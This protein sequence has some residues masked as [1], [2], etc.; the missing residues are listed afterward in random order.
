MIPI[1]AKFRREILR[2][3]AIFTGED[4]AY[5]LV[6]PGT[7]AHLSFY[8]RWASCF[9]EINPHLKYSLEVF[10]RLIQ[11]FEVETL[12]PHHVTPTDNDLF[13]VCLSARLLY[14]AL[15]PQDRQSKRAVPL[16]ANH[17]AIP[18][19]LARPKLPIMRH[20]VE[21]FQQMLAPNISYLSDTA[22]DLLLW[23]LSLGGLGSMGY[24]PH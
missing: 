24:S 21:T 19:C 16:F 17:I 7:L 15:Y 1:S 10:T 4:S 2:E 14:Q 23:M 12:Q 11:C 22:P 8:F 9:T 5:W 13:T 3:S 18:T 6:I 20:M